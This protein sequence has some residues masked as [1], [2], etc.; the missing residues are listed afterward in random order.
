M[1]IVNEE[2]DGAAVKLAVKMVHDN[3]GD[4]LMKG[5]V[6]TAVLLRAVLDKETGLRKGEVL[7]HF[8][9]FEVPTYPKLL[10]LTD[11]AMIIAPDLKT[12][13]ATD[14]QRGGV[15]E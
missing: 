10:G 15:H 6:P 7:S 2:N 11:A 13:I 8:A 4:I 9:L 3:E 12:K 1:R 5:N 14:Q